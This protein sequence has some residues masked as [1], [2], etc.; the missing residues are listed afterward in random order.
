MGKQRF[1]RPN[2][3]TT[4]TVGIAVV[5]GFLAL[6]MYRTG[7]ARPNAASLVM[8]DRVRD[9]GPTSIREERG[10]SFPIRNAGT[11][12]LVLNELDQQCG[13][14]DRVQRT[15]LVA[16]GETVEVNVPLDTRFATGAV[17]NSASF[18]TNDPAHPRFKLTVRAFVTAEKPVLANP[19]NRKVSVLIR[20]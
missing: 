4:S 18:T 7:D 20:Q 6:A 8:S 11:R 16:P 13:C 1:C 12:R 10:V 15:I 3:L 9:L 19:E 2:L 17:E 14:G 5:V